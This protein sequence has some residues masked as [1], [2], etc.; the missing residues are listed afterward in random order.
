M[1]EKEMISKKDLLEKYGISY[2]A[3]YRWKR[4]GL[5]PDDWFVKTASVTGQQTFFPKRLICDRV[6]QIM[7]MKDD[8]SLSSLADS[9]REKEEKQKYLFVETDFGISKF[10]MNEIRRVYVTN[11]NGTRILIKRKGENK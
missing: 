7:Q 8:V 3:L 6:E 5:I 9:F 1:D 11:E 10:N 2:G 4:M